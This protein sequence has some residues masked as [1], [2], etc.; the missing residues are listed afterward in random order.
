MPLHL[1]LG[2]SFQLVIDQLGRCTGWGRQATGKKAKAAHAGD[3][4]TPRALCPVC[5]ALLIIIALLR[6]RLHS[7]KMGP[8]TTP[9][10]YLLLTYSPLPL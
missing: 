4:G 6:G 9:P 3:T 1:G 10:L 5:S 7:S 2:C 8:K